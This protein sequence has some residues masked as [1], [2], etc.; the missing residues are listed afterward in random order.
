MTTIAPDSVLFELK[1]LGVKRMEE[2]WL[3]MFGLK[4]KRL[5]LVLLSV[6]FFRLKTPLSV[7]NLAEHLHAA[8]QLHRSLQ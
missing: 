5:S 2:I 1:A 4:C 6:V 8:A 3:R 7:A